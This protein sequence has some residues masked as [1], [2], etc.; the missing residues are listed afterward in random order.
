MY[1]DPATDSQGIEL[2]HGV[3]I[4]LAAATCLLALLVAGCSSGHPGLPNIYLTALSYQRSAPKSNSAIPQ[5]LNTTFLGLVGN[6]SMSI[7]AGYFGICI[8]SGNEHWTCHKN[9]NSFASI[10]NVTQDPLNLVA[11]SMIFKDSIIF[12]GLMYFKLQLEQRFI[13]TK[14]QIY[15]HCH[16]RRL[17]ASPRYIPCLAPGNRRDRLCH[18]RETFP[19]SSSYA[20]HLRISRRS[21]FACFTIVPM[22]A[23]CSSSICNSRSKYDLRLSQERGGSDG[24]RVRLGVSR[25]IHRRILRGARRKSQHSYSG[26]FDR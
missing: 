23:H 16:R 6:A 24:D 17:Y 25:V 4:V 15:L 8:R 22:A 3:F 18:G 11:N 10:V 5:T 2:N 9:A 12:S 19:K 13:L 20:F 21:Y 14:P 26:H 1:S 7:R